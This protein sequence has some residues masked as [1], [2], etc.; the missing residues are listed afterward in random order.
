MMIADT[1]MGPIHFV[2]DGLTDERAKDN[3]ANTAR[4]IASRLL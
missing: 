3:F 2:P 1:P 4:L